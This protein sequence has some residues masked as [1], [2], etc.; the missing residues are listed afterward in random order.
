MSNHTNEPAPPLMRLQDLLSAWDAEAAALH[1]AKQTGQARGP[2]TGLPKLDRE[3]SGH[4]ANGVHVLHGAP[5]VGKTAFCLQLAAECGCPAL[6]VTAEMAPL[7]LL[8]RITARKTG[9]FLGKFKTGEL[10]PQ[11]AGELARKAIAELSH[12]AILDATQA[13]P[14]APALLKAAEATRNTVP[15]N[16]HLLIIMDS[17][18]SWSEGAQGEEYDRLNEHLA[19]LRALTHRLSCPILAVAERNRQSMGRGGQ[20]ASAGSRKFE[21]GAETVLD[22][23]ADP[24]AKEDGSGEKPVTLHLRKNRHGAL[25]K[26][27]SLRFHGALQSYREA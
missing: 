15:E 18:H 25:G 11:H 19:A 24:D 23:D 2:V 17:V 8:R 3:L 27:I 7:E 5:G 16:R 20:S 14:T 26:A 9:T 1:R 12:L 4:L 10:D 13:Y 21:Y 6:Y 22:L